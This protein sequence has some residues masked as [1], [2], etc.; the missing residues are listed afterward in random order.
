[1]N[2][3]TK[4]VTTGSAARAAPRPTWMRRLRNGAVALAVLVAVYALLG[5]LVLPLVAKPR[6]EAALTE[7]SGRQATIGRLEFNP[8]TLRARV[9]DFALA[10]REPGRFLARFAA[11]D[12]DVSAA[13]LRYRAP[14]FDAVRLSQPRIELTRNAD[15]TYSFDDLI[16]KAGAQPE[17]PSPLFSLNNIEVDGAE[18]VLDDRTHR[19]RLVASDIGIGIPFLS[20]LPHDAEIRVTPRFEGTFDGTRFAMRANATSPFAD[21]R[22]ATLEWNLDALPLPKYAEYMAL[23]GG[24]RLVD[25]ALTTR[26]RLAFVTEKGV[27]RTLTLAG[28]ARVDK[29]SFARRDGSPLVAAKSVDVALAKLDWLARSIA[30]ER[31]AIDAPDADLRREP[32]GTLELVRL[33]AAPAAA[34]AAAR[35]GSPA[36]ASA[37]AA[38]TSPWQFS[39]DDARIGEGRLSVADRS[40]S[41]TFE[42]TLSH[43]TATG[44]RIVSSGTPGEVTL[45]FDVDG[46]ARFEMNGEVDVARTSARGRFAFTAFRLAKLYPFYAPVLNLD[47][48][49]GTLDLAGEFTADAA[50]PQFTLSGGTAKVADLETAIRDDRNPLWRIAVGTIEGVAFD[51]QRRSMAIDRVALSQGSLRILREANG[52]VNFQRLVNRSEATAKSGLALTTALLRPISELS[53]SS[54]LRRRREAASTNPSRSS[55]LAEVMVTSGSEAGGGEE[56]T[57]RRLGDGRRRRRVVEAGEEVPDLGQR[58]AIGRLSYHLI[59]LLLCHPPRIDHRLHLLADDVLIADAVGDDVVGVGA[60]R[61]R[62]EDRKDDRNQ[63]PLVILEFGE[64]LASNEGNVADTHATHVAGTLIASG[65]NPNARGMAPGAKAA[66]YFFAN[67]LSV[68][69]ASMYSVEANS[70]APKRVS[71]HQMS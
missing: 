11:L 44:R 13:S 50:G 8:F 40:V 65:V 55:G 18:V 25:G 16:A 66:T 28:T 17:G 14:V 30:L 48:R 33:L 68:M 63:K 69:V 10:D 45:A 54:R 20:S 15:G 64:R 31:V 60:E 2:D 36:A 39:I 47:V 26:L 34:S 62:D 21:T 61:H 37:P 24:I 53:R 4:P 23:P 52:S 19:K 29:P 46:G 1:M 59:G 27:A 43:V 5:F 56:R 38:S 35:A 58:R 41:P 3:A 51:L 7:A 49:S 42:V 22:E 70:A 6:A 71:F 32:D 67:D 57:G 12:L 9:I